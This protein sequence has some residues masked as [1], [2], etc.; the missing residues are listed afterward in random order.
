M[1]IMTQV[2][3]LMMV[4]NAPVQTMVAEMMGQEALNIALQITMQI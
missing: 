2:L 3:L 1:E 4:F